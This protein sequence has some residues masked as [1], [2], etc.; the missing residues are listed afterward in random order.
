LNL[1]KIYV[2]NSLENS[3]IGYEGAAAISSM[4][5][6]NKNLQELNLLGNR[7]EDKG[8]NSLMQV[9]SQNQY[10]RKLNLSIFI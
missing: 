5:I 3:N 1:S 2:I 8:I 10:I 9:L 4:L 7:I 6:V